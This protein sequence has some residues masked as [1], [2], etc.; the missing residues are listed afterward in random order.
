M[1]TKINLYIF[2]QII[3]SFLLIFFIFLSIAWLLQLTRLLTLTN[4]IQIDIFNV[5]YLSLFLIPNLL[6]VIIPFILIFGILL[7]FI[8]LN[9]DKEVIAIYS[10]GMQLTPIKF[11]LIIFSIIII[12]F[13]IMLNSFISPIVYEKY[14]IKEFD[15]RNT[16]NF[17]KMISS[18]FLKINDETT[19]DFKKNKNFFEDIFI[20][21]NN[22]NIDNLIYAKKGIIK[23]EKENFIFQLNDGFKLSI[24]ENNEIEKLAFSDYKLKINTNTN[25][26]FDNYDRNTL[27]ILDDFKN[28]DYLNIS[29]KFF[30]IIFSILIIVIFYIN[31]ILT[32][33]FSLKNNFVFIL[34][35]LSILIISQLLKNTGIDFLNYTILCSVLVVITLFLIFFKNKYE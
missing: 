7:C 32:I 9:R 3:K 17:N 34:F 4:L 14:K 18:N 19:V 11:S 12:V 6:S 15:L 22:N 26:E 31:N 29:Y 35:S 10:L 8:K 21:N 13:Y 27:T 16:V 28:K 33:N 1:I 23:T 24:N 5:I 20:S 25:P 30:D 2:T